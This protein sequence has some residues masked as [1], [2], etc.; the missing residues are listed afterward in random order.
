M[1]TEDNRNFKLGKGEGKKIFMGSFCIQQC[2]FLI[3]IDKIFLKTT[4]LQLTIFSHPTRFLRELCLFVERKWKK[5]CISRNLKSRYK[6][7]IS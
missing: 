6:Q 2:C 5:V 4:S 7:N 1:L 3:I